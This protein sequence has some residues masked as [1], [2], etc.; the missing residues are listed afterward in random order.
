MA[1]KTI[2]WGLV[3][4]CLHFNLNIGDLTFDLIP[5]FLGWC[6]VLK[7]VSELPPCSAR[8]AADAPLKMMITL[9][10]VSWCMNLVG[11]LDVVG[12]ML[13]MLIT[14]A[15]LYTLYLLIE[16]VAAVERMVSHT[17]PVENLRLT[18]KFCAVCTAILLVL[19]GAQLF[20]RKPDLCAMLVL[21]FSL[22]SFVSF[23]FLLYNFW[24][25][26]KAYEEAMTHPVEFL[27]PEE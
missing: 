4:T 10:A 19:Q 6:F 20:W 12:D 17:M 11:G 24:R 21:L 9:S 15:Q 27:P 26:A 5:S 13:S 18:W 23:L 8:T 2:F 22:S 16:L 1:V 14:F 25:A 7:G 3:I